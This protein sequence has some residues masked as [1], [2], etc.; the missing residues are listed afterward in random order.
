VA[1]PFAPAS[2]PILPATSYWI[3]L[4]T[5]ENALFAFDP[6][7]RMVPTTKTRMTASITAYSAISW[8]VS[9]LHSLCSKAP[10]FS[11]FPE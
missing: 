4:A 3:E 7:S 10:P 8:P 5:A 2:Q 6:T 9:S 1:G 11:F